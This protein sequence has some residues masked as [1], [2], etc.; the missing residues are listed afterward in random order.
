MLPEL[1]LPICASE[2][3][4]QAMKNKLTALNGIL[5]FVTVIASGVGGAFLRDVAS[6]HE[7]KTS[8]AAGV[9]VAS[10][11]SASGKLQEAISALHVV[12]VQ[13]A[14]EYRY[15]KE[16]A[17]LYRKVGC[18]ECENFWLTVALDRLNRPA[19]TGSF[20]P[21]PSTAEFEK[22]RREIAERMSLVSPRSPKP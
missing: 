8:A 17:S 3:S 15:A 16:L 11:L 5:L 14:D 2:I 6:R 22:D 4:S 9:M 19:K 21:A 1:V 7:I 12:V 13:D 10:D 18:D 20:Y